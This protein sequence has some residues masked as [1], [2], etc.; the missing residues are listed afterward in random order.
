MILA[1]GLEELSDECLYEVETQLSKAE[2]EDLMGT[3][4]LLANS[5]TPFEY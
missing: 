2:Q 4:E 1:F 3:C 5:C